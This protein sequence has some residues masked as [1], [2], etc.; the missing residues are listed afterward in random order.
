[1]F[2]G[3]HTFLDCVDL[4]YLGYETSCLELY[5]FYEN[6]KWMMKL[7]ILFYF[8]DLSYVIKSIK[9]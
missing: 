4:K 8:L 2:C 5:H 9:T 1:M 7:N 3:F 6:I